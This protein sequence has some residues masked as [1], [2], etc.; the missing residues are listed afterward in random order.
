M[1]LDEITFFKF[2]IAVWY[3]ILLRDELPRKLTTR[4]TIKLPNLADHPIHSR[5][6]AP[7]G[8]K[9]FDSAPTCMYTQGLAIDFW[10]AKR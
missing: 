2:E 1:I 4:I 8:S 7:L 5:T 3:R 6:Q 10:R 9:T